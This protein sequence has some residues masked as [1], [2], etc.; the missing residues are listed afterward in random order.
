MYRNDREEMKKHCYCK[1]CGNEIKRNPE[2]R[3]MTLYRIVNHK[4]DGKEKDEN[5]LGKERFYPYEREMGIGKRGFYL[6]SRCGKEFQLF[7]E[8]GNPQNETDL[9]KMLRMENE[10]LRSERL[11]KIEEVL[12]ILQDEQNYYEKLEDDV[13]RNVLGYKHGWDFI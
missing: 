13:Y 12:T 3:L 4:L 7:M 11:S 9:I 5:V 6:C 8:F 2:N 1:R 10:A